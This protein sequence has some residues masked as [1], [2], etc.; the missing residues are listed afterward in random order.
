MPVK[1]RRWMCTLNNPTDDDKPTNWD[2]MYITGQRE[3][4]DEGT[5][6]YQL[7]VELRAAQRLSFMKKLSARAH[8][9]MAVGTQSQC[10]AYC[11][12][13]DTRISE[14]FEHGEKQRTNTDGSTKRAR[15]DLQAA[16]EACK[17][18]SMD[19]IREQFPLAAVM[20]Q[21]GMRAQCMY[22]HHKRRHAEALVEY[23]ST[24]LREW[25]QE[26]VTELT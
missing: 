8:W 25:Q 3:R 12:K 7:Y 14:P 15:T 17:S 22:H 1:S 20:Y 26:V 6:H 2:V 23:E 10:I 21:S 4:A 24:E 19:E 5:E 11:T 9:E 18:G 13:T 16:A